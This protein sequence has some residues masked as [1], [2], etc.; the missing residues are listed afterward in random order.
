LIENQAVS[1][2][3]VFLLSR[4]FALSGIHLT[5]NRSTDLVKGRNNITPRAL[6]NICALA[7]F[8]SSEALPEMYSKEE[9]SEIQNHPTAF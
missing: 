2:L 7:T 8:C 9:D 6:N 5:I 3:R 4:T 1:S